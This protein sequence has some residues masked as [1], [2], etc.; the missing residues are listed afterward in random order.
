MIAQYHLKALLIILL[1]VTCSNGYSQSPLRSLQIRVFDRHSSEAKEMLNCNCLV[2]NAIRRT[3]IADTDSNGSPSIGSDVSGKIVDIGPEGFDI[4][5]A[6]MIEENVDSQTPLTSMQRTT[7]IS[8]SAKLELGIVTSI[9][10]GDDIV[11][12]LQI[13]DTP[14]SKLLHSGETEANK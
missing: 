9:A 14:I 1:F 7:K 3:V 10:C 2:Q 4:Q 13:V 12:K 8:L 5:L 11:C 6:I